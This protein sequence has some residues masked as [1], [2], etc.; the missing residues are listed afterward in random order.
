MSYT[1]PIL[2][3]GVP[4]GQTVYE[5]VTSPRHA[6]G[7]RGCLEDGRVF[8][9][10]ANRG[11]AINAGV[12]V[13]GASISVDFDDLA[14]N[15]ASEGDTTVNVTP[16]G[17]ATYALNQLEGGFLS[18]NSGANGNEGREYRITANPATTA[19]TAFD[20][21][22]EGIREEDFVAATTGTV[23]PNLFSSIVIAP[24]TAAVVCGATVMDV[25]AGST[26]VQYGWVQTWG[27][28]TVLAEAA[29]DIVGHALIKSGTTAG[30]FLGLVDGSSGDET[31]VIGVNAF[32]T[33]ANDYQPILLQI[34]P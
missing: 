26:T 24:T 13:A 20:L 33:V 3:G 30:S 31:Q 2:T 28:A 32:T 5:W 15:T 16:V 11:S 4:G 1:T 18:I 8:Y 19:A 17:T 23:W 27:H 34:M 10:A 14:T 25:P 7:T 12:L 29:G 21:S 9:Y 6:V 22:V